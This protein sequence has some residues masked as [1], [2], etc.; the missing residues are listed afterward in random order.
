MKR[1]RH[2]SVC[3]L[4]LGG[5]AA[6]AGP[7]LLTG[8][9][10]TG[11]PNAPGER[12]TIV[13]QAERERLGLAP[14][15]WKGVVRPDVWPT[16]ERR[17]KAIESLRDR[18]RQKR[19]KDLEAFQIL[20]GAEMEGEGIVYVQVQLKHEPKGV[21]ESKENMAA[22]NALQRRVLRS[23]TA[24]EFHRPFLFQ[25]A[26]ALT[27]Y[28][29]KEGLDKLAKNPEVLGV[30]LDEAPLPDEPMKRVYD[31]LAPARRGDPASTRP[32]VAEMKVDPDIYR[33]LDLADRVDVDVALRGDS[34]P[35]LTDD[36]LKGWAQMQLRKKAVKE[37]Q[38]RVLS[39]LSADEFWNSEGVSLTAGLSGF[40]TR[41]GFEK[42]RKHP[43]LVRINLNR[44]IHLQQGHTVVQ[45]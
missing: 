22:I 4:M 28:V 6:L 39:T 18:L 44:R 9:N 23:L 15:T 11:D 26:A 16:L 41:E 5:A 3:L 33:A 36:P 30:C 45:P 20:F 24:L 21:P 40:I 12:R 25:K 13:P 32:G 19:G 8:P 27:G 43:D 35:K 2:L 17:N 7:P 29:T 31:D 38:D 1:F 14:R 37:L 42:L 34:L 10:V